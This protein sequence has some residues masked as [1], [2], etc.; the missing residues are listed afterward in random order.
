ML[1]FVILHGNISLHIKLEKHVRHVVT[2]LI[3]GAS[4]YQPAVDEKAYVGFL[5]NQ[6]PVSMRRHAC[7]L[8]DQVVL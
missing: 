8:F 1:I 6:V 7:Y 5:P 2:C 3:Q 4:L